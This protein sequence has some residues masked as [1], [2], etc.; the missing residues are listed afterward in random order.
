MDSYINFTNE[1][2]KLGLSSANSVSGDIYRDLLS[3]VDSGEGGVSVSFQ[4]LT[5]DIFNKLTSCFDNPVNLK[6]DAY[7]VDIND[8]IKIY[9]T[10]SISKL[11]ALYTI[12]RHY[13]P[14]GINKGVIYNVP[15]LEMRGFRAYL[16]G[17]RKL[18]EF[19]KLIDFLISFGY[20]TLMLEIGGAMEYKRHPEINEGWLKYCE[21]VEEFNGKPKYATRIWDFPKNAVHSANAEEDFLT[22]EELSIIVD[23]CRERDVEIIPEVPTFCHVDYLLFN[24][25]ELA[26]CPDEPIPN[27]AC[28]SNEDYYKLV[29]DVLD[30]VIEVFKP[31]RINICHDEAY[32]YGQCPKCRTKSGAELFGGHI[33]RL[34]DYLAAKNV[35][36]MLWGD[37]II[38]TWHGGNA[39]YHQKLPWDGKRIAT[40]EG[41]TYKVTDFMCHSVEEWEKKKKEQPDAVAWYVQEKQCIEFLPKDI[42]AINWSWS[43][44]VDNDIQYLENGMYQVYGNFSVIGMKNFDERINNGV[45]GFFYSHWARND[46]DTLQRV[47]SLFHAGYNSL[48]T[49]SHSYSED[50][51]Y[52]NVKLVSEAVYKF[53]NYDTLMKKHLEITHTT[54]ALIKHEMFLIYK[55]VRED[56]RM[57]FYEVTYTDDTTD[58]I[59]IYWG[60][61]IGQTNPGFEKFESSDEEGGYFNIYSFEPIG[62]TKL[63]YDGGKVYYTI[64]VPVEKD[65]KSVKPVMTSDYNVELKSAVVVGK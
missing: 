17:K 55:I 35:K 1:K 45:S 37:G 29:F 51:K 14:E 12:K 48:A 32:V 52:D 30:E 44:G 63:V 59:P 8:E 27:N 20:N 38:K 56:Y 39:A 5:N 25:R 15:K 21:I 53:M 40:I 42:E 16:P 11:Y 65:V 2:I 62:T 34:H 24:H 23:Y 28:P 4:K 33:I 3:S 31:K 26:E 36:T 46:F 60:L 7:I 43:Y 64:A 10:S 57:G 58:L 22:Q 19:K 47:G 49:W 54:D 41:K 13:T 50:K 61:N 18:D 6:E 9:Y